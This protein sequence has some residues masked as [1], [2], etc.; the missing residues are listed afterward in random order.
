MHYMRTPEDSKKINDVKTPA[1]IISASGM[2]TGG[3]VHICI[4]I[5]RSARAGPAKRRIL[6]GVPAFRQRGRADVLWKMA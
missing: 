6:L 1:I 4:S 2:A 3:R 5:S